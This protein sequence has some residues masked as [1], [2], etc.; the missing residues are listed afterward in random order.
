MRE[1]ADR[2][3]VEGNFDLLWIHCN[4]GCHRAPQVASFLRAMS[5]EITYAEADTWMN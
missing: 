4:S 3:L 2:V 5:C 1:L